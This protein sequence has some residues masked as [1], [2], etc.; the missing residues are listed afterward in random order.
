M[1]TD[2]SSDDLDR[3]IQCVLQELNGIENL[4]P[5]QRQIISSLLQSDN[6]FFT[7]STNREAII[8]NRKAWEI[9]WRGGGRP[10]TL[11]TYP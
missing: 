6:I 11:N 4:Y 5:I 7:S 9:V 2:V 8:I 3:A 1:M 10:E